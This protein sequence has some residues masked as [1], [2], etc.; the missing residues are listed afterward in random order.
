VRL[1]FDQNLSPRLLA[2]LSDLYPDSTHVRNEGLQTA[3]DST[4]W[5]YAARQ[6]YIIVSKDADFHQ[7][8]FVLG[9]P[10]KVIWIQRGNCSTDQIAGL[11]RLYHPALMAFEQ[12]ATRVVPGSQLRLSGPGAEPCAVPFTAKAPPPR[13][14]P[15]AAR[16][17]HACGPPRVVDPPDPPPLARRD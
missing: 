16:L 12:D 2:L 14:W 10:P 4:V 17:R 7:R 5:D 8:S 1:L 9:H 13:V 6:G 15:I 11:L 3:D